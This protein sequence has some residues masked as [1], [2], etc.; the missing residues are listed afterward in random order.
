ML[1]S[2][3]SCLVEKH[4]A[5]RLRMTLFARDL[6]WFMELRSVFSHNI[7]GR[8]SPL[9]SIPTFEGATIFRIIDYFVVNNLIPTSAFFIT[10]LVGWVMSREANCSELG[11]GESEVIHFGLRWCVLWHQLVFS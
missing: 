4:G 1:E 10:I 11:L 8:F 2:I 9:S 3:V 7:W 6:A 5:G